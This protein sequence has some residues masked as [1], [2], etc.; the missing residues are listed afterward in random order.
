MTKR[1]VNERTLAATERFIEVALEAGMSPVTLAVAWTLHCDFVG[2][3]LIGATSLAQL[4]DSL[5]AA[6]V[7]LSDEVIEACNRVSRDI[8]YPMG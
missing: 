1:F 4:T 5:A 2:S 7:K 8:P 3:T 6:D